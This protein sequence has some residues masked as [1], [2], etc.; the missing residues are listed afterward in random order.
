MVQLPV[1]S[2]D[3]NQESFDFATQISQ[4]LVKDRPVAGYYLE[5]DQGVWCIKNQEMGRRFEIRFDL[6]ADLTKKM[7]QH[8]NPKK[9]LF[10][11]AIGVAQRPSPLVFDATVGLGQD[12]LSLIALGCQVIGCEI[13]PILFHLLSHSVQKSS[14][15]SNKFLLHEGDSLRW[16]EKY[17]Q[18]ADCFFLDPMF[19]NTHKKSLPK[20]G[21]AFLR[22]IT[23]DSLDSAQRVIARLLALKAKRVV[24][25]RP[26]NSNHLYVKPNLVFKGK[27]IRYDVYTR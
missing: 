16:V 2:L 17:V 10:A 3:E 23:T 5:R 21:L 6:E 13:N 7:S 26:I 11:R 12:A 24:V 22:T 27:M 14:T 19:E 9:D 20:K 1:F 25:K 4:A 18:R 8:I 15:L